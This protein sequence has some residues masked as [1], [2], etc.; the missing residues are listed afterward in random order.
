[1]IARTLTGRTPFLPPLLFAVV[2]MVLVPVI[3]IALGMGRVP[4]TLAEGEAAAVGDGAPADSPATEPASTVAPNATEFPVTVNPNETV[5]ATEE[6]PSDTPTE[7]PVVE[8][9][10]TAAPTS[11]IVPDATAPAT[12]DQPEDVVR[13]AVESTAIEID[14]CSLP[15]GSTDVLGQG[16]TGIYQCAATI[17]VM[18]VPEAFTE[19]V[20]DWGVFAEVTP[21]WIVELRSRDDLGDGAEAAW[22]PG[23]D[24]GLEVIEH[25]AAN[26]DGDGN[27]AD[28]VF[29]YEV[30]FEVRLTAPACGGPIEPDVTISPSVLPT[31]DGIDGWR[32]H[33]ELSRRIRPSLAVAAPAPVLSRTGT[34]ELDNAN[35]PLRFSH[36]DQ[37]VDAGTLD[38]TV[39]SGYCGGWNVAIS[40]TDFSSE[41]GD[42]AFGVGNLALAT[43][44]AGSGAPHPAA[45]LKLSNGDQSIV[46][47]SLDPLPVGTYTYS[48]SLTLTIP[49]GTPPGTYITTVTVTT[50]AAP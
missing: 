4:A 30:S 8:L 32:R 40:A 33:G 23:T 41:A 44:G 1:M 6:T 37:T 22:V 2:A 38:L 12:I 24:P 21:G 49:G 26:D 5:P 28:D 35:N 46:S 3:A 50:S 13:A 11:T 19:I 42:V 10:P 16:G 31:I 45:A 14:A 47:A 34:G 17:A 25:L 18:T 43:T 39:I 29:V 7:V 36:A 48:F 27:P 20:L 15:I 9:D